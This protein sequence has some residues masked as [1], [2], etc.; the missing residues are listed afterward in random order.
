MSSLRVF[1]IL[2][3]LTIIKKKIRGHQGSQVS[4]RVTVPAAGRCVC[5][6]ILGCVPGATES[7]ANKGDGI[8]FLF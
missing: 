5:A 2:R 4:D 3:V 1:K 6:P 7:L 8:I